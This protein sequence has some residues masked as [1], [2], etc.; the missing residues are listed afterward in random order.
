MRL[1]VYDVSMKYM[2]STKGQTI[3]V[4]DCHYDK[5]KHWKWSAFK[6]KTSDTYCAVRRE[7]RDGK[8]ITYLMHRFIMDCPPGMLTD[9]ED[10]DGMNN[11][12]SNLRNCTRSQNNSNQHRAKKGSI[13]GHKGI[14]WHKGAKKWCAEVN[15]NKKKYYLGLF[16]NKLD[17]VEAYNAKAKELHGEFFWK[18]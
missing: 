13:S 5:V 12:C 1:W 6:S 4:C 8:Q 15:V 7:R 16:K 9:H 18:S 14:Y 3:K 11:D 10:G 2:P 17:A